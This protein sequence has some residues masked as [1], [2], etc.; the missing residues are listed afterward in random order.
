MNIMA[1]SDANI[2]IRIYEPYCAMFCAQRY[3]LACK[4]V[5]R[6]LCELHRTLALAFCACTHYVLHVK[7]I[8]A[9]L[10]DMRYT[11]GVPFLQMSGAKAC[12][13]CSRTQ[14]R[15]VR[16]STWPSRQMSWQQRQG[17]KAEEDWLLRLVWNEVYNA[18][19]LYVL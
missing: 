19:Q 1:L 5:K 6:L 13:I 12:R 11:T 8:A 9:H 10:Q 4:L 17:C 18:I 2:L 3:R 14:R 16:D 7:F 15:H